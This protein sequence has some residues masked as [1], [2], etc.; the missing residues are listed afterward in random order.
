MKQ[1]YFLD[2]ANVQQ[3]PLTLDQLAAYITPQTYVWCEGF[4]NWYPALNVPEVMNAIAAAQ[5]QAQVQTQ[6]EATQMMGA[7]PQSASYNYTEDSSSNNSKKIIIAAVVALLLIGG[8]VAAYF[9]LGSNSHRSRVDDDEDETEEVIEAKAEEAPAKEE[10]PMATSY[11]NVPLPKGDDMGARL[12]DMAAKRNFAGT[13]PGMTAGELGSTLYEGTVSGRQF[14]LNRPPYLMQMFFDGSPKKPNSVITGIAVSCDMDY[15]YISRETACR[16][17][18]NRLSELGL[19][20]AADGRSFISRYGAY[21]SGGYARSRFYIYY[22]YPNAP[23]KGPA[24]R[25]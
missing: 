6:P 23:E 18:E 5:A 22:Y 2:G 13:H 14:K 8:G 21:V 17:F 20:R 11:T 4:D 24:P 19:E 1:Y 15:E 16:D 7:A 9:L 25:K 3:G 10:E 12:A